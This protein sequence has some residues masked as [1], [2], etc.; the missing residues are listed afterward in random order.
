M[1]GNHAVQ[2]F[3]NALS[4]SALKR[5]F[6]PKS[7]TSAQKVT[8]AQKLSL[9]RSFLGKALKSK[10]QRRKFAQLLVEGKISNQTFEEWNRE[11][12]A[13]KLPEQQSSVV[14]ELSEEGV[15]Q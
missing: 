4:E 9:E 1:N 7:E 11:T 14:V 3:G 8:L 6:C 2:G 13:K 5:A 10:A 15:T 12:G